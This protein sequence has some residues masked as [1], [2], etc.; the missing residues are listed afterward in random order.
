MTRSPAKRPIAF[1]IYLLSV[2]VF[3]IIEQ[4]GLPVKGTSALNFHD[5]PFLK[6]MS[7]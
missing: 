1:I 2:E 5:F 3:R 6:I 4:Y 7:T